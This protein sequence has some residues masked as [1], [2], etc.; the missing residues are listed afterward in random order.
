M[1][2]DQSR[3]NRPAVANRD[4]R[5]L[6]TLQVLTEEAFA[7]GC[8]SAAVKPEPQPDEPGSYLCT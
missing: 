5:P 1:M 4:E 8:P 6:G 3:T 2:S 7:Q